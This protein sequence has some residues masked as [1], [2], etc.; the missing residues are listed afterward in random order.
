MGHSQVNKARTH[1]RIVA[2][3]SKQF[4][5]K[6][7]N[8]IGVADLMKAAGTTAGGFYK[9]FDS[10]DALVAEA[11]EA[12][13]CAF[14][15]RIQED[16]AAGNPWTFERLADEYLSAT[17]RDNPA[18]GCP[19]SAF[20]SELARADARTR[21]IATGHIA[22]GLEAMAGLLNAPAPSTARTQAIVAYAAMVGAMSL[23]RLANDE[24]LSR[25]ILERTRDALLEL[26]ARKG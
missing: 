10:R 19:M 15:A 14:G 13:F 12:A 5:E 6:G 21:T 24:T 17:H 26:A 8:G 7:L 1:E 23:A 3:A 25:E 9:H 4:R 16:S 11:V 22:Q 20:S 2:T 18:D